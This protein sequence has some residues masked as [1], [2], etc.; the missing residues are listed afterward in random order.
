MLAA[1][2][3]SLTCWLLPAAALA[4]PSKEHTLGQRVSPNSAQ[5]SQ[6][7]SP[8]LSEWV[9]GA[10][11]TAATT[12]LVFT[13][14]RAWTKSSSNL[15]VAGIPALLTVLLV[16]PAVAT[17]SVNYARNRQRP[18]SAK[19]LPNYWLPLA[20]QA[21]V[22]AGAVATNTLVSNGRELALLSV[23][24]GAALGTVATGSAELFA[25]DPQPPKNAAA[26]GFAPLPGETRII[27]PVL[28]GSF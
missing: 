27:V 16:P 7:T 10:S 21:L 5:E 26:S 25:K 11:V 1:V 23:V 28:T 17:A 2:A 15:L 13:L 6:R 9:L 8:V 12:P 19:F 3:A 14:A 20:T 22:I 4:E 24:D 18:N